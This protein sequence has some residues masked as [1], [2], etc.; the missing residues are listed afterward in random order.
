[1][2]LPMYDYI[3][4]RPLHTHNPPTYTC[5]CTHILMYTHTHSIHKHAY[6]CTYPCTHIHICM[7]RLNHTHAKSHVYVRAHKCLYTHVPMHTQPCVHMP[8]HMHAHISPYIHLCNKPP[9]CTRATYT[10]GH[11]HTQF[12]Y[13]PV[14]T[15]A[16]ACMSIHIH[17]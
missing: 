1:M 2:L 17:T 13:V 11:T 12:M 14:H 16:Y 10:Q 9:P 15:L 5:P 7:H 6:S 4:H 3:T 8:D